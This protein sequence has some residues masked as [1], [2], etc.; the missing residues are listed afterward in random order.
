MHRLGGLAA[1]IVAVSVPLGSVLGVASGDRL[2]SSIERRGGNRSNT[3]ASLTAIGPRLTGSA[4]YQRAAEWSADQFRAMGITRVSLEPFTIEHGWERVSA[5][6]RIVAPADRPLHV[7]SLGWSPS[8]PDGG[9][10]AEVVALETLLA[11]RAAA[12]RRR[13]RAASCCC[14]KGIRPAISTRRRE[15]A[16]VS[17]GTARCG[18]GRDSLAG[19][20]SRQ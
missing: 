7:A 18:R 3:C 8:T 5:R 15:R 12:A 9:V 11:R 19:Q 1:L 13:C 17:R 14:P 16:A 4:S 6:A 2:E 10:E 20:R